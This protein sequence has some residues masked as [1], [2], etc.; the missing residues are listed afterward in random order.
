MSTET[1]ERIGVIIP[2]VYDGVLVW[3]EPDGT[4]TNR[5]AGVPGMERR[6]AAAQEWIDRQEATP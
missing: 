2:G 5:W 3:E 6:A 4:Y 1:D